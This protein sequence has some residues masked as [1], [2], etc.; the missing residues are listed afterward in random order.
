M[1]V[2]PGMVIAG[3]V[4]AVVVAAGVVWK[5]VPG[6]GGRNTKFNQ[7]QISCNGSK[8]NVCTITL[9]TIKKYHGKCKF[10]NGSLERPTS[11]HHDLFSLSV[12]NGDQLRVG[13]DP[14][15]QVPVRIRALFLLTPGIGCPDAPFQQ[16]SSSNNFGED[17]TGPPVNFK[18]ITGCQY[19]LA[20][21]A[22]E[23]KM[24]DPTDHP[25]DGGHHYLCVDPH[26][27]MIDVP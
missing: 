22:N 21:Q 13:P 8:P 18:K 17:T 20:V 9:D 2:K 4:L 23:E 3:V 14:S 24:N 12:K 5:F 27:E 1:R 25:A 11:D 6:G 15:D 16:G 26:F 7:N 19:E 10:K